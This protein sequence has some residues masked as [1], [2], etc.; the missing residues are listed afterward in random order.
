MLPAGPLGS[1]HLTK[2]GLA[3]VFYICLGGAA[4]LVMSSTDD[5]LGI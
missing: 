3:L 5:F 4:F 2:M 1:M